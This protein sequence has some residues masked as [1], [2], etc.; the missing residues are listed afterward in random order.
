MA[1]RPNV[2]F[3]IADDH[4][5]NAI[6]AAGDR[7]VQT[8]VLDALAQAGTMMARTHINGGV[9]G[10]VCVPSRACVNTGTHI[11]QATESQQIGDHA[12]TNVI[13]PGA[14][15]MPSWFRSHGYHT[16]AIGKWHN[17]TASFNAGFCSGNS[18]FFGG[19]SEHCQV[20]VFDYNADGLYPPE[21][22]RIE[23][24]F[25]TEL[26]TD[27]AIEFIEQYANEDPFF[28]YLAYT[29]PHDPRTAPEPYASMYDPEQ[30][31][32]PPSYMDEHPFDNGEL[33]IRDEKLAAYPRKQ[34]EV[35][36]HIADY[37]A[38]I[39]HMDHHIGSVLQA[40]NASGQA[41]NTLIV[42]T[43][44]HGLAVG[45]HGL[46]GKQNMYDHSIRVPWLIKGPGV[47]AGRHIDALV[48][49]FD[50]FPTLC[51]LAGIGAPD[52]IEGKSM[53]ALIKRKMDSGRETVYSL[54]K[55]IQRMVKNGRW[56]MILYRHS[57]E[58]GKGTDFVQ[59]FDLM[60]D[61]WELHNLAS[62]PI[63]RPQLIGLKQDLTD[64]MEHAG[65]PYADLFL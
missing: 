55:D 63:Y 47:P 19:M 4:R 31:Q 44:D 48:Y 29:S 23:T 18:L 32:L 6:G 64:W 20:P 61:P 45:Q 60:N 15:T 49:Q 56:K 16:H 50:I 46:L 40:L 65:D 22:R 39:S 62:D 57:A 35:R 27:S 59:L 24:K 10:A 5:Y 2:I 41:D 11:F 14:A 51:D 3:I 26:F 33:D 54:Y 28:L 37:Y 8:P 21:S 34:E 36:R 42:Y 12:R 9:D 30:I 38:M 43:A 1:V 7:T 13:R 58:T 52:D 53:N 17:D 25:S